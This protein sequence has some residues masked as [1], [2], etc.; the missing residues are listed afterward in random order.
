MV[1]LNRIDKISNI[2]TGSIGYLCLFFASLASG[3]V[4]G[5]S[6]ISNIPLNCNWQFIPLNS[7][8][9]EPLGR[10]WSMILVNIPFAIGWL[11]LYQCREVWHIFWG[12]ISLNLAAGLAK[13]T[14]MSYIGEIW[15]EMFELI[16]IKSFVFSSAS[17]FINYYYHSYD[18]DHSDPSVRGLCTAY[19]NANMAIGSLVAYILNTFLP[20]RSIA[21]IAAT[22]PFVSAISLCFVS[23]NRLVCLLAYKSIH[24]IFKIF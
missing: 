14:L 23:W 1:N 15:W 17:F 11:L 10:K 5:I 24:Y 3:F 19:T 13:A 8:Q 6:I 22:I 18:N 21:L 16:S 2:S 9:L 20:W 12:L 4:T 7:S